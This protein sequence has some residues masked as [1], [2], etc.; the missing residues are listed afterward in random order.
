MKPHFK[1]TRDCLF[2]YIFGNQNGKIFN[3]EMQSQADKVFNNRS[4]Y[5]WAK[6]YTSQLEN[7]NEYKNLTPVICINIL[8]FIFFTESTKPHLCFIIKEK[9]NGLIYSDHFSIHYI[10]LPKAQG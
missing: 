4:L 5:Y 8:D 2:K 7:G 6:L 10:E 3:I 1:V 9:F